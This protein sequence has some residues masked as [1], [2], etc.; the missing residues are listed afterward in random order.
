MNI[1]RLKHAEIDKS[2]YDRCVAASPHGT[3]Y[4]MSWYL[5]VV[6]PGWHL[7]VAGDYDFVMPIPLKKRFGI[8]YALQPPFCQQL[9]LFSASALDSRLLKEFTTRIPCF[10]YDLRFNVGNVFDD[11]AEAFGK[12]YVLP[13][14]RP[15]EALRQAYR[16]R[17]R[18]H[19]RKAESFRLEVHDHTEQGAFIDLVRDNPAYQS[20]WQRM[21]ML[22]ALIDAA[23]HHAQVQL[24]HVRDSEQRL[25]AATFFLFWKDRIYYMVSVSTPE[26]KAT[27]SMA[28][29]VDTFIRRHAS[30]ARILDFEGSIIPGVA[31]FYE[32][33][34]STCER[35]PRVTKRLV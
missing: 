8:S 17:C 23:R 34:G 19:V 31:H 5:D 13:L 21:P 35:Y 26:G 4:A 28:L 1:R 32:G 15:Y 20:V 33:F 11:G 3:V 9:G 10:I 7:L 30:S 2:A 24:W 16:E 6:S 18:R 29:L 14:D 27:Q 22:E 12:N 25:L